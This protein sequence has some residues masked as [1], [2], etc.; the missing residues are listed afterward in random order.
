M[1]AFKT[2]NSF[3]CVKKILWFSFVFFII[4]LFTNSCKNEETNE[5][6]EKPT[7][8]TYTSFPANSEEKTGYTLEFQ[9]EFNDKTLNHSKWPSP[10]GVTTKYNFNDSCINIFIDANT[11][12]SNGDK[13]YNFRVS[14]IYSF[15][16]SKKLS[17]GSYV[18]TVTSTEGYSTQYGYFEMRAKLP[19][20]GGGGHCAWWMVGAPNSLSDTLKNAEID[21]IEALFSSVNNSHPKFGAWYDTSCFD[22]KKSVNNPYYPSKEFHIYGM[23]WS[24]SGLKFY[25]D[26]KLIAATA[27]SPSYKMSMF[28]SIYTASSE[29]YWSG[30]DN[31]IYP[32]TFSID[33]VRVWKKQE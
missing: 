20:C 32:K 19:D 4:L 14:Q 2:L 6:T 31:G 1:P 12:P 13:V 7:T 26:N 24:P 18:T 30:S 27:N 10:E 16:N 15:K 11:Q 28:L 8:Y 25:Y 33:Y 3:N 21:I 29:S 9:D 5:P 23:D 22:W 17:N